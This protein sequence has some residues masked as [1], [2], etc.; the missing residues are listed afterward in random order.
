MVW[1]TTGVAQDAGPP[2]TGTITEMG[3][4]KASGTA[5]GIASGVAPN[6]YS[7]LGFGFSSTTGNAQITLQGYGSGTPP[8]LEY[9]INGVTYAFPGPGNGDVVGPSGATSGNLAS[10]SGAS[11]KILEDA[12]YFVSSAMQPVVEAASTSAAALLLGISAA[13]QPVVAAT[14]VR[15]A[16]EALG[17]SVLLLNIAALRAFNDTTPPGVIF[18]EGYTSAGDNGGGMF[19]YV[20]TDVST[21]DNGGTIIVDAS[22]RRW[23]RLYTGALSV[24]WFGATGNGSTDDI[25][26]IQSCVNAAQALGTGGTVF[27]PSGTYKVSSRINV[28]AS[29]VSLVGNGRN[30]TVLASS[31]TTDDVIRLADATG[32]QT[33]ESM[34][35]TSSVVQVGGANINVNGAQQV[36]IRDIRMTNGNVGINIDNLGTQSGCKITKCELTFITGSAILLGINSD[37]SLGHIVNEIFIDDITAGS[38][39]NGISIYFASGVYVSRVSLFQCSNQAVQFNPQTPQYIND[40][41]FFD[42]V[43]D[44][45]TADGI[46]FSG[47]GSMGSIQFFGGT[48]NSN[49]NN[50]VNIGSGL[51]I[52]GVKFIGME[53]AVNGQTGATIQSGVDVYF[54]GCDFNSNSTS[55]ANTYSGIQVAADVSAFRVIGCTS[56]AGGWTGLGIANNQRYGMDVSA[57]TSDAYIITLN[58]WNANATGGLNDGGTG[59]NKIVANNLTS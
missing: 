20:S 42:A 26:T 24:K 28:T 44:T 39:G 43:C 51:T 8:S 19:I 34:T 50:G 32:Y 11:G 45:S 18:L 6:S 13:M 49:G 2:N 58:V 1:T 52:S 38:C 35:F 9:V 47:T 3:I 23:Y 10:F 59:V 30:A 54:I 16:L 17:S 48:S 56:G 53:F 12:G 4:V 15:S 46:V 7:L 31:S 27:F 57:G 14:T 25:T 21:S 37:A 55:A 29:S 5:L 36:T 22:S 33:I 40:V 41:Q